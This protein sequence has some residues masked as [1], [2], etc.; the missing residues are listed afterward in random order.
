MKFLALGTRLKKLR[1]RRKLS[2]T[3]LAKKIGIDPEKLE[4]IESDLEQ[5]LIGTLVSLSKALHV[6]VAD[7]FRDRPQKGSFE[8]VRGH[9]R[10]KIKPLLKPGK[11]KIF[12]YQY[13]LLTAP[14]ADKHLEAY[15][16]EV[17]PRQSQRPHD[18]VTHPGEE[19][20][21][22]LEGVIDGE[23]DGRKFSLKKGDSLFFRSSESHVFF[24]PHETMARALVVIY[25][26]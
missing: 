25:P 18:D 10:E 3:G 7:I 20:M 11:G 4:R 17:P 12:D 24:N 23:I 9:E 2:I 15:L 26:F 14:A 8:I 16:V 21:Y 6:N 19:F 22:V 1:E 13:E 5:P